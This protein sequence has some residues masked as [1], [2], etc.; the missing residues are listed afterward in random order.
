MYVAFAGQQNGWDTPYLLFVII[1]QVIALIIGLKT[2]DWCAVTVMLNF[3]PLKVKIGE[4][5]EIMTENT[6]R[7][8]LRSLLQNK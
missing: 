1:F 7:K 5:V 8:N 6:G 2:L 3:R 4:R